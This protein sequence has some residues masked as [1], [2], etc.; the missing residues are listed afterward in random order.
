LNRAAKI[1]P[2]ITQCGFAATEV[3]PAKHANKRERERKNFASVPL[4]LISRQLA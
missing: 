3:E 2:Q 4:F 1:Q